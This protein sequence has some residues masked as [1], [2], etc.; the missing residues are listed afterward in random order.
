MI[1]AVFFGKNVYDLPEEAELAFVLEETLT[2]FLYG[3]AGT[4]HQY[5]PKRVPP[6]FSHDPEYSYGDLRDSF[7]VQSNLRLAETLPQ[8]N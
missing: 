3:I 7:E 1:R 2:V 4:D 6:I 8:S 5:D